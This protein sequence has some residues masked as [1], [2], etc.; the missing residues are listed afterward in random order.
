MSAHKRRSGERKAQGGKNHIIF[1][2]FYSFKKIHFLT[3]ADLKLKI[4]KQIDSFEKSRLEE[5]YCILVK[6]VTS[7]KI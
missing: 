1:K 3:I 4:F 5:F 2:I 7:K 6:Y